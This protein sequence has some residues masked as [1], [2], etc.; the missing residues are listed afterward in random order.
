MIVVTGGAGFIGSAFV[1]K[2]N[3]EGVDNIVVVDH[4]GTDHKWK[5]LA[6]RKIYDIVHKDHFFTWL[7]RYQQDITAVIHMG[8]CSTTTEEDADYLID[9]NH[10][11]SMKIFEFCSKRQIPLIY[12]SS[13]ATYGAREKDFKDD[14]AFSQT[15]L[16]PINKYGYSKYIFDSWAL[17]QKSQPSFWAGLKFF[18]VYGPGEY[19]KGGQASVVYHAVPQ[20]RE[21]GSLRLFKSH[22]PDI[23]HGEQQR[24]FVYVKDVVD[25]MYYMYTQQKRCPNGLY[26][27]GTGTARAFADLGKAVFQAMNVGPKIDWIDM[28]KNIR[29][30]YQYYTQADMSKLRKT[31]Y[32]RP[33]Q[34]LEDGIRDYVQNYLLHDDPY[35]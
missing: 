6:K 3:Q 9:N 33:F 2:L 25:V 20:I 12:A 23:A 24:D 15:E 34:S 22:R 14:H 17:K 10:H 4:L 30:Q 8:A 1:W 28:P 32:D 31:G 26:N 7:E 27:V 35:L 13:A 5:N 19:H 21:T 16:Q 29:N 11:Y 18:N